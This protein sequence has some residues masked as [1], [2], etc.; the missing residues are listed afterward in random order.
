MTVDPI[1]EILKNPTVDL[2]AV[3]AAPPVEVLDDVFTND[4]DD[5]VLEIAAASEENEARGDVFADLDLFS[6][7]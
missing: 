2:N 3:V 7:D 5:L 6:D 4:D 1:G